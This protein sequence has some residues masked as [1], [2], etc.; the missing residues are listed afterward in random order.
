[1]KEIILVGGFHEMIEL[2]E[3][4]GFNIIGI[5]DNE[6]TREYYGY[7]VIGTDNDAISLFKQY[8][9]CQVV[10]TPDSPR[11][12]KKLVGIYRAAGFSFATIIHPAATVSRFSTIGEG[13]VV[14]RGVNVSANTK[15]GNF[16]K[17]NTGCNVMHDNVIGDYTTIAPNSVLLGYVSAG[18]LSYIGANSTILPKVSIGELSTIGAGAVVTKNVQS[19]RVVAGVPAKEI[20]K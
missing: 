11:L 9:N 8:S 18:E 4:A 10:I 17:L 19:K 1:M 15:V 6:L 16:C 3:D 13:T 5:I 7:P 2:C 12:R 20:V 14:Q